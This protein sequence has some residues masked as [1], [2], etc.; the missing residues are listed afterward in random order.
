MHVPMGT[1]LRQFVSDVRSNQ[2]CENKFTIT[3]T[4][5]AT[6]GAGNTS[7]CAQ[8]ITV[9]DDEKPY[10]IQPPPTSPLTVSCYS[11][12]PERGFSLEE[13]IAVHQLI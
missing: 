5:K 3:R 9:N 10:F 4:Y 1:S 6:D 12:V 13:I 2:I 11:D 8:I 7:T